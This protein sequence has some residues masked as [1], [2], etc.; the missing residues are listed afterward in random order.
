MNIREQ[1]MTDTTIG[2]RPRPDRR[3]PRVSTRCH[4][5]GAEHKACDETSYQPDITAPGTPCICYCHA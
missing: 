1:H 5:G 2:P 4:R 3:D